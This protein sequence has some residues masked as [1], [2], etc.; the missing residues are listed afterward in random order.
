VGGIALNAD[1][2]ADA[3]ANGLGDNRP[4]WWRSTPQA[5]FALHPV[6]LGELTAP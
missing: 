1:T 5:Y 2:L 4:Q 6:P 3:I